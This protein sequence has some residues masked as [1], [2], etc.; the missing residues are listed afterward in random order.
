MKAK[1]KIKRQNITQLLLIIVIIVFANIISSYVFKR[2]D[3]T[4]EGRYT[5]SDQTKAKL[6]SLDGVVYFKVYLDGELPVGFKKLQKSV[7]EMLDEFRVYAGEN[8]QYD[9]IN[10]SALKTE[11]EREKEYALLYKKGINPTNLKEKDDEGKVSK[12]LIWPGAILTYNNK[13]RAVNFLKN[14]PGV[15]P[16]EN[17]NNSI[18]SLEYELVNAINIVSSKKDKTIGFLQGHDEL[19][20]FQT[21]D[22][23]NTLADFYV[24]HQVTID[25]KLDAL[26]GFDALVVAKPRS[27][28]DEKDKF[29]IDQF[30]MKGG[31]VL[32][33]VDLIDVSMDSLSYSS[34]TMALVKKINIHDQ[35]FR[36]GA[37]VN[38]DLIQ[39]MRSAI[40]PVNVAPGNQ[41][42]V[43]KPRPW[44]YF[45]VLFPE[46]EHPIS[47]NLNMIKMEF[48]GTVDTVGNNPNI[49]KEVLL[50]SS[51]Y[52][53]AVNAPVLISLQTLQQE[54]DPR[55][56]PESNLPLAV[57]LE[58]KFTSLYKNRIPP[59]I[60]ENKKIG[61][62]EESKETKMIVIGDGDIIRNPVKTRGGRKYFLPLGIDKYYKEVFYEGNK[63]FIINSLNYL[64]GNQDIMSLRSK[65]FT[66]RIMDKKKL[67]QG[68]TGYRLLNVIAPLLPIFLFAL[69]FNYYRKK[70]YTSV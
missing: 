25:G 29:I 36:Y 5:L 14:K 43:W 66:L 69:F 15:L 41:E 38:L 10:P 50:S 64:C 61:F 22:V 23:I 44:H 51:R 49:K 47:K 30:I 70:K 45:P 20:E 60:Q 42:P 31:K 4:S 63:N 62:Q 11:E 68:I 52:S 59:E 55:N 17:L 40:I 34:N 9:F 53:K 58:G 18:Q 32:W 54:P 7:K 28:F 26:L 1:S 16:E 37:R 12:K 39:D 3:L 56:Y 2:F 46:E 67:K 57:L 27:R 8:I 21:G 6:D 48:A 33:L 13:E 19:S 65:E 35:L 24:V